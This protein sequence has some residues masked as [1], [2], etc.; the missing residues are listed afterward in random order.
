MNNIVLKAMAFAI[1]KHR[2]QLDDS[3]EDYFNAHVRKVIDIVKL[4]TDNDDILCAAA[5]HDTI[6]DTDTKVEEIITEFNQHVA[7]LVM[8]VTH[9]GSKDEYGYYF[10][11]LKS[12]EGIMI[13]LADRLSNISRM[14]CWDDNRKASYLKKTRFWK[15]GP[16]V[17]E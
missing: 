16:G 5:L 17:K 9:E 1:K 7:D 15:L 14:T 4:V 12:Q 11:R 13:K 6:E 2:G 3:G 8:E 10:P